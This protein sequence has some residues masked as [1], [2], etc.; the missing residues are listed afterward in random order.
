[1]IELKY[2]SSAK[3]SIHVSLKSD[4][5][6]KDGAFWD[7]HKTS[8]W[9]VFVSPALFKESQEKQRIAGTE[10]YRLLEH[11]TSTLVIDIQEDL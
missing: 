5:N 1:M 2:T 4:F 10:I 6:F 11:E 8:N 7:Y 9:E 3:D